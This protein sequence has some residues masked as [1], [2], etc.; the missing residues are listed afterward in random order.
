MS[1]YDIGNNRIEVE[2]TERI[3][4]DNQQKLIRVM[5]DIKKAGFTV[6]IDDFGTGYSSLNLLKNMPADVIKLDKD[7]LSSKDELVE[8]P[9]EKIIISSVIEMA[10]KLHITTVAEGVE[11]KDQCEMLCQMGCDIAQGFYYAKPMKRTN[12]RKLLDNSVKTI[13]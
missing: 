8:N 1:Q 9:K 13:G 3:M 4:V 12:F 10:K 5:N 2:L 6:S 7:F 11:T